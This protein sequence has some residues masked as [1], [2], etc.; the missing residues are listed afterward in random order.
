MNSC[1]QKWIE[2]GNK[3]EKIKNKDRWNYCHHFP[4]LPL[5]R[6]NNCLPLLHMDKSFLWLHET[7]ERISE[8]TIGY[9]INSILQVN[10]AFKEQVEKCINNTQH[11]HL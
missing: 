9:M 4:I 11:S 7:S 2:I 10:K 8:L 6:D 5:L 3:N 1:E